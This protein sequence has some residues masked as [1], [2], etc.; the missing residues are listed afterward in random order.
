MKQLEQLE[1]YISEPQ[2]EINKKIETLNAD[3]DAM[4]ASF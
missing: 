1:H 4:F 2:P 3:L